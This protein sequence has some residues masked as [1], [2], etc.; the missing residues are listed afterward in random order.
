MLL[1]FRRAAWKQ[2]FDNSF[3]AGIIPSKNLKKPL[4]IKT[5]AKPWIFYSFWILLHS[6]SM[7]KCWRTKILQCRGGVKKY[8]ENPVFTIICDF[9]ISMSP[10]LD[11]IQNH[12][13]NYK[14]E[15]TWL[16]TGI[17]FSTV[18]FDFWHIL[19]YYCT[20]T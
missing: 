7:S 18:E 4:K 13:V 8:R 19:V 3:Y 17:Q 20:N 14:F 9:K 10:M 16:N 5:E 1:Q 2:Y 15:Y 11:W 6:V 12:C